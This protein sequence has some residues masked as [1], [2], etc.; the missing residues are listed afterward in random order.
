MKDYETRIRE[1]WFAEHVAD[2]QEHGELKVLVW[3]KP[4]TS[5]YYCRYVFDG[6]KMY[7]SGDIGEAVFWFTEKADL[8]NQCAYSLEYFE[9]KL[10]AYGESR[11]DFDSEKAIKA[12][13]EWAKELRKNN[14]EYDHDD[15]KTLFDDCRDCSLTNHWEHILSNHS[16]WIG[17][18]DCDYWEWMYSVGD[19]IPSRIKGYLVGLN[20]AAEQLKSSEKI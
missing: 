7:V 2:Y 12:L 17:E 10:A 4:G 18:I 9:S 14:T 13:K 16:D 15:M 6:S 19:E 3:K 11:R 8:F 5:M 20:M 1:N